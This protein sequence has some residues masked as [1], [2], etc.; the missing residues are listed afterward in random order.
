MAP[1][2]SGFATFQS[3][4]QQRKK[5]SHGPHIDERKHESGLFRLQA[6][7]QMKWNLSAIQFSVT[8]NPI[9]WGTMTERLPCLSDS[10]FDVVMCAS[11]RSSP[12]ACK[13]SVCTS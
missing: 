7:P 9:A 1:L 12:S 8:C 13:V 10:V 6:G 2:E 5:C 4:S 3:P 11:R